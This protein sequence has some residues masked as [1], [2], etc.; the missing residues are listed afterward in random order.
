VVLLSGC[1][2]LTDDDLIARYDAD[3]DGVAV[4]TD[5]ND[6][7]GAVQQLETTFELACGDVVDAELEGSNTLEIST[8]THPV[9]PDTLLHYGVR[10]DIRALRSEAV[11]EATVTLLTEE[12]FVLAYPYGM[13]ASDA[14]EAGGV[15]LIAWEGPECS[16]DACALASPMGTVDQMNGQGGWESSVTMA[17]EPGTAWYIVVTGGT[18]APYRLSVECR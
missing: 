12:G 5:C 7:D 17:V 2:W 18:G 14:F 4:W 10:E 13:S 16:E 15:A 3:Q 6:E 8:C 1:Q 9:K 11:V